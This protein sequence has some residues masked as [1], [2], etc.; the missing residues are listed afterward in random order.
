M[1]DGEEAVAGVASVSMVWTLPASRPRGSGPQNIF[2]AQKKMR[3][4]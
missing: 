3:T 4:D 2:S 1:V